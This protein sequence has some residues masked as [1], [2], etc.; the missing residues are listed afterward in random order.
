M[1]AS[2]AHRK[3]NPEDATP[4]PTINPVSVPA[5]DA[6]SIQTMVIPGPRCTSRGC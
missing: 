1:G 2:A 4:V 3:T 5:S 6:P